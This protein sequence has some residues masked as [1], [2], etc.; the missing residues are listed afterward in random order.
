MG[1]VDT[2]K[3]SQLVLDNAQIVESKA[4]QSVENKSA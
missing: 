3:S 1:F 2:L 4:A